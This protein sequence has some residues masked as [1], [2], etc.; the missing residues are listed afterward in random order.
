MANES[1]KTP[2]KYIGKPDKNTMKIIHSQVKKPKG[3]K[4]QVPEMKRAQAGRV[5]GSG[6]SPHIR[7]R[8]RGLTANQD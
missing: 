1:K 7:L 6:G 3:G 8:C 4:V 5:G 2:P